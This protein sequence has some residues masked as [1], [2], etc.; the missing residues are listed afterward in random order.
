MTDHPRDRHPRTPRT[1]GGGVLGDRGSA[2][3]TLA[4]FFCGAVLGAVGVAAIAFFVMG[5]V[6]GPTGS[7]E[8]LSYIGTAL[9]AAFTAAAVIGIAVGAGTLQR[10]TEQQRAAGERDTFAQR[11]ELRKVETDRPQLRAV[12]GGPADPRL[13]DDDPEAL[14]HAN[15]IVD[16]WRISYHSGVTIDEEVRLGAARMFTGRIGRAYWKG[17]R[18][19]RL[20]TARDGTERR[21]YRFVDAEYQ[22]ALGTPPAPDEPLKPSPFAAVAP[23]PVR[24]GIEQAGVATSRAAAGRLATTAVSVML[25]AATGA[26]IT[27]YVLGRRRTR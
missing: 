3:W 4:L 2:R 17:A 6:G 16:Y 11:H 20:A 18:A 12:W 7:W 15:E 27:G 9:G 1:Y 22:K 24:G 21:F 13:A 14:E 8:R 25:G 26:A 19:D 5:T 10:Q 23:E